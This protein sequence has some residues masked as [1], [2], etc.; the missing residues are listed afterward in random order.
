MSCDLINERLWC[1][2]D[3]QNRLAACRNLGPPGIAD[4]VRGHA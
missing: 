1:W 2:A 4:D 3:G